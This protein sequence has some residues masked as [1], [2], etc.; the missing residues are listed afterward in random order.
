MLFGRDAHNSVA[1]EAAVSISP[2]EDAL[3][4]NLVVDGLHFREPLLLRCTFTSASDRC[5]VFQTAP[6]AKHLPL[7]CTGLQ[8]P[9]LHVNNCCVFTRGSCHV[10]FDGRHQPAGEPCFCHWR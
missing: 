6:F 5:L 3:H 2:L 7:K 1:L 4:L 9:E 10:V 8:T